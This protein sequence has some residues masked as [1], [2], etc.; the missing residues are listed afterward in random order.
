[1]ARAAV[2]PLVRR[3]GPQP[4]QMKQGL[5]LADLMGKVDDALLGESG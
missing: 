4:W 1:M 5:G 2:S 3:C